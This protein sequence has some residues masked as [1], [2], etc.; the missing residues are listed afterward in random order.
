[1]SK[2]LLWSVQ[3]EA[4][5]DPLGLVKRFRHSFGFDLAAKFARWIPVRH[6]RIKWIQDDVAAPLVVIL[7]YKVARGIVD[8]G[9]MA[10]FLHLAQHW[11]MMLDF[12]E[13]VSPTMRKCLFSALLRN[14]AR[15]N[16]P[17]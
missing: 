2:D 11:R 16:Y 17:S 15:L 8:D 5:A 3:K 13:P 6:S 10:A 1:M 4:I 7:L 12:P 9:A 14:A